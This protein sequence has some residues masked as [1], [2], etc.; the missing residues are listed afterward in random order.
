MNCL[1]NDPHPN[2]FIKQRHT[3][4]SGA[5]DASGLGESLGGLLQAQTHLHQ[6]SQGLSP[7]RFTQWSTSCP[8]GSPQPYGPSLFPILSQLHT[9]PPK[10]LRAQE[11][12]VGKKDRALCCWATW[13]NREETL[14]AF[15]SLLAL[16]P[17][18]LMMWLMMG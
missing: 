10:I 9:Y 6:A 13:Q 3:L 18:A 16:A 4:L 17:P 11:V 2:T 14:L 15:F 8:L 12:M 5:W 7:S 1:I